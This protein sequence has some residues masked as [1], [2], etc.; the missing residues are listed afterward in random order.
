MTRRLAVGLLLVAAMPAGRVA[1]QAGQVWLIR[2]DALQD[3]IAVSVAH[4]PEQVLVYVHR[5][6]T[7]DG[8]VL[9]EMA[10]QAWL[11]KA[12]GTALSKYRPGQKIMTWGTQSNGWTTWS[13]IFNFERVNPRDLAA[14][15]VSLDG[16]LF[17]RPIS[18]KP[19]N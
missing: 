16:T 17:V 14:V 15:V 10:I 7:P 11:L 3:K 13:T 2:D 19:T 6:S 8:V 12:D 4:Q 1:A 18:Q 9:P 5:G